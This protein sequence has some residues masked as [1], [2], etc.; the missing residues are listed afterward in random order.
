MPQPTV[1]IGDYLSTPLPRLREAYPP[2][3]GGTGPRSEW[4]GTLKTVGVLQDLEG[5]V[6]KCEF[7]HYSRRAKRLDLKLCTSKGGQSAF[8]RRPQRYWLACRDDTGER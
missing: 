6:K 3:T 4:N 7:V 1:Q 2:G 5:Q 8:R